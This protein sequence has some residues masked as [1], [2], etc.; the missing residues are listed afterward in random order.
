MATVIF[1][2]GTGALEPSYGEQFAHMEREP[3]ARR[4]GSEVVAY[5]WGDSDVPV[6]N[7]QPFPY[8]HSAYWNNPA[9]WDL[10]IDA[11]A[12]PRAILTGD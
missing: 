6:D 7:R 5:Q 11:I 3:R 4:P 1:V 2:H 8:F 12:D 9:V 10:V